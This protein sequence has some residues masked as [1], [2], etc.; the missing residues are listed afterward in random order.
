[1]KSVELPPGTESVAVQVTGGSLEII[2]GKMWVKNWSPHERSS[3]ALRQ[4]GRIV[5]TVFACSLIGL[6]VHLLLLF[7]V[8][9]LLLTVAGSLPYFLKIRSQKST[10]FGVDARCPY[11]KAD[12]RLKPYLN[13]E[14]MERVTVQCPL[15]GQTSH[16]ERVQSQA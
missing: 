16:A 13:A 11:C 9:T 6:V 10:F 5:G 3:R 14:A 4:T 15:C 8:P 2:D 1:M 12:G 7:I